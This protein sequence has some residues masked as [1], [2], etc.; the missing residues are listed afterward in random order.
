MNEQDPVQAE[1]PGVE[2]I[3]PRF[4]SPSPT[5]ASLPVSRWI[6]EGL[7]AGVF[8]QPRLAS[9]TPAAWQLLLVAVLASAVDLGA[10]RLG[11]PG[12]AVF[13][14]QA[15]LSSWWTTG[16]AV[17]LVWWALA[18]AP[19]RTGGVAT[20][21]TLW[22]SAALPAA[23]VSHGLAMAQAYEVLPDVMS[24]NAW[25]AWG[26][27]GTLWAWSLSVAAL[28]ARRMGAPLARAAVVLVALAALFGVTEW[29]FRDRW[30]RAD[31]SQAAEPPTLRL[32]Q[33]LFEVQQ[34]LLSQTLDDIA[35]ERPGVTDVYGLVFAP[36]AAEDVFL[37]ESTL[38]SQVLRERFDAVGR[39]VQLN[40]HPTTAQALPWATPLNLERAISALA[41]RMDRENDVLVV[42]LTSH[43][44]SNF[45]L[46]AEN[47]TL[48]VP[49]LTPQ[50]L[51]DALDKA[52]IKNR[53]IAISACF[54][55][56]W[57][58]PLAGDSTLVMTA[59]DATHTSYGCG[60]L[61]ELT[62]FGRAMWSEQLRQTHSFSQAFAQ[63]VPIIRQREID[64]G[65]SDGFSNPQ[66]RMGKT[67]A[68]VLDALAQ[69]LDAQAR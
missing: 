28:L 49:W 9:Y 4:I 35:P 65:K 10:A 34:Q 13:D 42:Y 23:L 5:Q 11:V 22:F 24:T 38:V 21:F 2:P 16:V 39:V 52:G 62:F 69:T 50:Q 7:R 54:S 8:L 48:E 60:R 1:L 40:N 44:A 58:E 66:I 56:G 30:W 20:W 19:P 27:Y 12:P 63:A 53:V 41:T 25:L 29:Q 14:A 68:P 57:V 59:A 43:G 17:W 46:A 32:S 3:A 33:E 45:H 18:A 64:A 6:I 26:V 55:G 31:E 15:W 36:Y 37:R 47:G 61:S 51:R 67:I